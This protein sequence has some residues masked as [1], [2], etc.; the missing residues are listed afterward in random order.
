MS[1]EEIM[2]DLHEP[3]QENY[4]LEEFINEMRKYYKTHEFKRSAINDC[5]GRQMAIDALQEKVFHN[6]SDEFYGAMQVLNE[7]PSALPE[8]IR[9][10]DCKWFNTTGCAIEIVDGLN[11]PTENDFCSF[12]ERNENGH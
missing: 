10:K 2:D 5:V 4:E 9:C 11:N 8:I 6:L 1:R 12:A 3:Q 7:L